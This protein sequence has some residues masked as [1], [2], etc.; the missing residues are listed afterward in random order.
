MEEENAYFK[1]VVKDA[2][3]DL[4]KNDSAFV[5]YEEQAQE[6]INTMK[7]RGQEVECEF[8]GTF[9]RLHSITGKEKKK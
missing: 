5:F 8:D 2:L 4:K 1:A 3:D 9:Y 6:V 7:K